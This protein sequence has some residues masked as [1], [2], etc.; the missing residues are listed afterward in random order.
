MTQTPTDTS[1]DTSPEAI[2][3]RRAAWEQ[4]NASV[5]M[6]GGTVDDEARAMQERHIIGE[7]TRAEYREWIADRSYD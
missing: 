2:A 4:A 1:P 5:E 7:I 3:R 6:E